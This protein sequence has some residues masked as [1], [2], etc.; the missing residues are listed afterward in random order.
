VNGKDALRGV[1]AKSSP[2]ILDQR[3]AVRQPEEQG[4]AADPGACEH[5]QWALPTFP[6]LDLLGICGESLTFNDRA[7]N[8]AGLDSGGRRLLRRGGGGTRQPQALN[9]KLNK[10]HV[11]NG[12]TR[13]LGRRRTV[14]LR[15]K[16]A[17]PAAG[18]AHRSCLCQVETLA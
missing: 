11:F 5:Q 4:A 1:P 8:E 14:N 12:T 17:V 15:S 10:Q 13:A 6:P 9:A 7:R 16:R 2:R 3:R 18:C